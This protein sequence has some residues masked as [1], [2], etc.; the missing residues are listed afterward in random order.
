MRAPHDDDDDDAT[1]LA[2]RLQGARARDPEGGEPG[3]LWA[4]HH[5]VAPLQFEKEQVLRCLRFGVRNHR[6][7]RRLLLHLRV[8]RVNLWKVFSGRTTMTAR[9]RA[10]RSLRRHNRTR[11]SIVICYFKDAHERCFLP[12]FAARPERVRAPTTLADPSFACSYACHAHTP[13]TAYVRSIASPSSTRVV[14]T[15]RGL[16]ARNTR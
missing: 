3:R 2:S 14:T 1:N 8:S 12:S 5:H 6:D 4:H 11:Q 13:H 16:R 9:T 15:R 10:L 7:V